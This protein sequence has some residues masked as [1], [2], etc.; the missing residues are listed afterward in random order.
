MNKK[1]AFSLIELSIVIVI[2][3]ILIVGV[4][5]SKHLIAKSRITTAQSM[6]KSSPINGLFSNKLWLESSLSDFSLGENL[7]TGDTITSWQNSANIQNAPTI[8]AVGSGAEYANTINYIQAVKFGST[9]SSNHLQIDNAE[10]LNGTNYTIIIT[11]KRIDTN[12][13]GGNYL[14]GSDGSFAVGYESGTAIIQ[15]HG[16]EA[17]NDNQANIES[18]S[19]Y[20]NK[21]RVITFTHS[22]TDGNKIYING[23]LANEDST[24]AAKTHLSGIST[25]AIGNNY[26]GEIGEIAIFDKELKNVERIEI[27]NYMTDK[28]GS[29][30]NRES[31]ASCTSGTVTSTGCESTC[32]APSVN[33]I[34]SSATIDDGSSGYYACDAAGYTGNTPTYTCD[35]GSLSSPTA[36]DC[37]A[38]GC[39]SGYYDSGNNTC[40]QG[41]DTS[42]I[43]GST[44]NIVEPGSTS[45]TCDETGYDTITFLACS[46][47]ETVTGRC[48]CADGYNLN[49]GVCEA[50]CTLTSSDSSLPS[51]VT[52]IDSGSTSYNC[53]DYGDYSGTV[54]FDACNN[55]ADLTGVS[56]SCSSSTG[57]FVSV[58]KTDNTG[59]SASNQ[60][61]LPLIS[62]G[63]YDFNVD[64]GDGNSDTGIT[65]ATPIT[66]TYDTAGTYTVTISGND[67]TGFSFNAGGD[68]LKLLE[69]ESWGIFSFGSSA[70]R[71]FRGAS[72]LVIT[73]TDIPRNTSSLT[74]LQRAFSQCT[75]LTTIPN[76]N[77][78]NVSN[79]TNM[80][81]IFLSSP[82]FNQDL[83]SW[84]TSS[85]TDMSSMFE[86]ATAFNGNI[87]SWDTSNVTN[88]SR[89]FYMASSFNQNLSS[90]NVVNVTNMNTMFRNATIF[91]QDLSAW[92]TT[93]L[94]NVSEM[95][96]AS[97]I[98]FDLSGWDYSNVTNFFRFL[99]GVNLSTTN[100]SSLLIAWS[101]EPSIASGVTITS[102]ASHN[103][104]GATAINDLQ[105]NHGW[106]I[107]DAGLAP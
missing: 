77:S 92:T 79:V 38:N 39:A 11:E 80:K 43:V 47:G 83:N 94:T 90:W 81:E 14:L 73:A 99:Q 41:C 97:D 24:S 36:G 107:N 58:W 55:G 29:P 105:T 33:G 87:S 51:N 21:P 96:Y 66:H 101:A 70:Y 26:N 42:A 106:T 40:V 10:F 71:S 67:F 74:N 69:I 62:G 82:S 72:N 104:D 61:T 28:W 32:S 20:S 91:N 50:Q 98:D 65:S 16:E 78:W 23:T 102:L 22:S 34:T 19:S 59:T 84:D 76:L 60:I 64:W 49:G 95:F 9:S 3:G 100:W 25:L 68:K 4:V 6:T 30:N 103:A 17:S 45:V 18:V 27:E 56:G 7:N 53:S 35:S 52:N 89:M 48:S 12:S 86:G 5:G 13:G 63:T 54:T 1:R 75:S 46:A 2:I 44:T 15:T 85:A 88:M 93:S 31:N 8:S 57:P 37:V